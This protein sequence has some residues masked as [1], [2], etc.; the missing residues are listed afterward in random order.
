MILS[1]EGG[2]DSQIGEAG[3]VLSAGQR[4]RIGLARA[5]YRNPFLVV[6]DEPNS[7]LDA[8]GDMALAKSVQA[9]RERGSIVIVI[10]HRPS[11]IAALDLLLVIQNGR[12]ESFGPKGEVLARMNEQRTA[13]KQG[14]KVVKD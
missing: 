4:Q 6:L 12:Q 13:N 9:M 14:L 10:A 2:Y 11:A 7:N 8:D 1:L 3:A 5:L